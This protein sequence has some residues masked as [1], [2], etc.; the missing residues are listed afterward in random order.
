M[1]TSILRRAFAAA[2]TATMFAAGGALVAPTGANAASTADATWLAQITKWRKA[3]ADGDSDAPLPAPPKPARTTPTQRVLGTTST[4]TA[5][6]TAAATTV[7]PNTVTGRAVNAS[8][9]AKTLV[10]Y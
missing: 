2:L 10:L 5:T 8:A 4:A 6:T 3:V 1:R 9:T 7:S